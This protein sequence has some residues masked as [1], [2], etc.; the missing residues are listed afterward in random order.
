MAPRHSGP[1]PGRRSRGPD[2]TGP[3]DI[4]IYDPDTEQTAQA[5]ILADALAHWAQR[6]PSVPAH[7]NVVPG[8][9]APVLVNASGKAPLLV[10]GARGHGGL[11]GRRLGSV[12][13]AVL[14]HAD[15]PVAIVHR[16]ERAGTT[17]QRAG[18]M[19]S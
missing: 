9:T 10:L 14:H 19:S 15:C 17:P 13:H 16:V 5:K 12:S 2:L 11:P 1:L 7:A 3:T 4:L 6:Y 8:R 18:D